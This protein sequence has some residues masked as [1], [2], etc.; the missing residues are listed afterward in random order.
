MNLTSLFHRPKYPE[1]KV[2]LSDTYGGPLDFTERPDVD[3]LLCT[4]FRSEPL[5]PLRLTADTFGQERV[6]DHILRLTLALHDE[7]DACAHLSRRERRVFRRMG[8]GVFINSA[9]RTAHDNGEPFYVAELPHGIRVVST[10]LSALSPVRD[11]IEKLQVLPNTDNGL[12]GNAE[13]FRSSYA[14]VLLNPELARR[15][16]LQEIDP[17][18]VPEDDPR[19]KLSYIDRYGNL[20]THTADPGAE[21]AKIQRIAAETGSVRLRIGEVERDVALGTSLSAAEPGELVLYGNGNLDLVRKWHPEDRARDRVS[22]SA[23]RLFRRPT[24]G[25][26]VST[27]RIEEPAAVAGRIYAA[28]SA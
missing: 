6:T 14:A 8:T 1:R 18:T 19:W 5:R 15:F 26:P 17:D 25:D 22:K 9:P 20:I 21:W 24:I 23:Y 13:Q 27:T 16:P 2:F 4:H 10:P 11:R 7:V 3:A 12:Y 28:K